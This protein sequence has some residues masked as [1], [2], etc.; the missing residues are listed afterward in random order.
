[1]SCDAWE[2]LPIR[3]ETTRKILS[4]MQS[5]DKLILL[6]AP[7]GSGKTITAL[8][9]AISE[10]LSGKRVALFFRT[11]SQVNYVLEALSTLFSEKLKNLR[12]LPVVGKAHLCIR[13]PE[14]VDMF[15]KWCSYSRCKLRKKD[16]S[17]A[18][19]PNIIRGLGDLIESGNNN[20]FCPY[21]MVLSKI[22]Q[23][24]IIVGT[25]AFFI[26][27]KLY[28]QL[29]KVNIVIVDEAH[30]LLQL[31]TEINNSTYNEGKRLRSI[32]R[33]YLT[34]GEI[35]KLS[36]YEDYANSEGIE[37]I[38]E[39]KRLK[40][41]PPIRLI[42]ERLRKLEKLILMSATIYP[43]NL[44][45]LIFAKNLDAR[46]E[47]IPGIMKETEKRR[48]FGIVKEGLS[49]KRENRNRRTYD[50]Y[51]KLIKQLISKY[52]KPALILVPSY[53]FG[54]E[55]AKR[56]ELRVVKDPSEAEND[57]IISVLKGRFSEGIDPGK[58]KPVKL[59]IIAGLP[60]PPRTPEFL[61]LAKTYAQ[62]YNVGFYNLVRALEE[63]DMINTIIQ[64]LGRIGRRT[65]GIG[66]IIDERIKKRKLGI[67]FVE[68]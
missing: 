18:K 12:I 41:L 68:I 39:D 19:L 16:Y 7:A 63:S 53:E 10:A 27:N 29:G 3:N 30:G 48:I 62:V 52:G 36:E 31:Y 11:I 8:A 58:E 61:A 49:S 59:L 25:Q 26:K 65:K 46:I 40:I 20:G 1:M 6:R 2:I 23:V 57:V 35:M 56:L 13:K 28:K 44:F 17:K 55:I 32:R 50:M 66:I 34:L 43:T 47:V 24:E 5:N 60:Y 4:I 9:Y 33:P 37:V 51:A 21:Y 54:E 64:A 67:E 42:E 45:K 14:E 38:F 22:H 15:P